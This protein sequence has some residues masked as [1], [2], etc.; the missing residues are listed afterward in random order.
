MHDSVEDVGDNG[1]SEFKEKTLS[2]NE[3]WLRKN[4]VGSPAAKANKITSKPQKYCF[5]WS[6]NRSED[7]IYHAL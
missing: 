4:S 6:D 5:F 7:T 2:Y 3:H 1:K